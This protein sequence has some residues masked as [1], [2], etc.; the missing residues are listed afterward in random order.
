MQFLVI[1][2]LATQTGLSPEL[3]QQVPGILHAISD[4]NQALTKQGKVKA[5]WG[6]ADGPGAAF[7]LDV[8]SPEELTRLIGA[9]PSNAFPLTREVHPIS[10]VP[11]NLAVAEQVVREQIAQQAAMA[12]QQRPT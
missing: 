10:S 7:V 4:Y 2:K 6:F 8:E 9:S 12:R 5:S 11:G 3:F 1:E